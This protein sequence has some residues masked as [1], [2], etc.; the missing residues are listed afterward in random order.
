[1]ICIEKARRLYPPDDSAHGFEHVLRV[2]QL[3]RRIGLAEGADMEILETATLLHDIARADELAGRVACHAQEGAR[4]AREVLAEY[5]ADRVER[6][7]EAIR[8]HRFRGDVPPDSLEAR[9]LYDADKLDAIGAIGI[10][11]AYAMA[12]ECGQRLWAEVPSGFGERD[13]LAGQGDAVR[14]GH[15][16]VHEFAYKLAKLKDTLF[17]KT[18]KGIAE[19]RHQVMV[20][21][22]ERLDREVKGEL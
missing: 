12:G 9:I 22:F 2:L 3:V 18:A 1:M 11:R 17:T 16:P 7:A 6:V 15:T 19:E 10:A 20:A 21:F 8:T 13:R 4:R 5:P 14:E